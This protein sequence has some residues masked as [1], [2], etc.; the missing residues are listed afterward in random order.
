MSTANHRAESLLQ[1]ASETLK[2][3]PLWPSGL[4]T[5]LDL[6]LLIHGMSF[7]FFFLNHSQI[8]EVWITVLKEQSSLFR[9]GSWVTFFL[10]VISDEWWN[11]GFISFILWVW[12]VRPIANEEM[13]S[14][15]PRR[16][17]PVSKCHWRCHEGWTCPGK[18]QAVFVCIFL[19]NRHESLKHEAERKRFEH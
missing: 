7:F 3:T 6:D 2:N 10:G 8:Q 15:I 11:E 18:Y 12:W 14:S 19:P 4:T 9:A 13:L 16:N 1:T 5:F 17:D